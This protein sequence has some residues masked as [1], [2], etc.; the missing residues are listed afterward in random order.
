[1]RKQSGITS[2]FMTGVVLV[3]ALLFAVLT[4]VVISSATRSQ[5]GQAVDFENIVQELLAAEKKTLHDKLLEKGN[6]L[7]GLLA[8]NAV[9]LILGYDFDSLQKMADNAAADT[10]VSSVLFLDKE[11]KPLTRVAEQQEEGLKI[12]TAPVVFEDGEI[13]SVKLGLSLA[14]IAAKEAEARER[15]RQLAERADTSLQQASRSLMLAVLIS[16]VGCVL[17]LCLVIFFCLRRYVV[18][19]VETIAAHLTSGAEEVTDASRQL[20][21]SGQQLAAGASSQA[22]SLEET[23]AALEE[24]VAMT[25][26]N[27][28]NSRHGDELM[29]DAQEVVNQANLSMERQTEAMDAISRSSE[30]TSKIIKTIDEIAFQTNLLALNAAV[31]AARAGEAGAGFAVVAEEVRNLA[32]RAAAAAKDTEKLIEGI[33]R[34]VHD[35]AGLVHQ[36]NEEFARMSEKIARVATLVSEIA[37]ASKEQTAGFDQISVSMVE[38]DRVTQDTAANAEESASA[39]TEMHA[40]AVNLANLAVQLVTLVKGG[41]STTGEADRGEGGKEMEKSTTAV[42]RAAKPARVKAIAE[43]T[44]VADDFEEF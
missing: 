2:K 5:R 41:R 27:S 1:M 23:S 15:N 9:P 26:K 19:P 32:M 18:K 33:V 37:E 39:A 44:T 40:Q 10:D 21:S 35:G 6:S 12:L 7:A 28:E 20:E 29:R 30:E 38:I 11:G 8:M 43:K 31:E 3:S 42:E 4:F 36:T 14:L 13:G 16:A 17:T 24:L 25:R 22:A 34:Q